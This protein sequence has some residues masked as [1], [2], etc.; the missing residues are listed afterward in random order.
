MLEAAGMAADIEEL[1]DTAMRAA[2]FR[3]VIRVGSE[4]STARAL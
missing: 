3:Q 2:I 4:V 1:Q